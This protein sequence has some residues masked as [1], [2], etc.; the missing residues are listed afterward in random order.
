MT[1]DFVHVDVEQ[2]AEGAVF[3]V[4]RFFLLGV[5]E[6]VTDTTGGS[7]DLETLHDIAQGNG[8]GTVLFADPVCVRQV[9]ADRR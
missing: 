6:L 2:R 8:L 7:R 5:G 3:L 4:A 1:D 9:D